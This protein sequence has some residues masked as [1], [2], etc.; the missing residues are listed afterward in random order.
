MPFFGG[1]RMRR[2]TFYS[3][4]FRRHMRRKVGYTSHAV[5]VSRARRSGMVQTLT[6]GIR[7]PLAR[8]AS[9]SS[10]PV[11]QKFDVMYTNPYVT[12]TATGAAGICAGEIVFRLGS[13]YDPYFTGGGGQPEHYLSLSNLYENYLVYWVEIN[14]K[15]YVP[16]ANTLML[17]CC[18]QSANTGYSLVG[19]TCETLVQDRSISSLLMQT[20]AAP[21]GQ[22]E[23]NSGRIYLSSLSGLSKAMYVGGHQTYG[24]AFGANPS[25]TPW[26]RVGLTD[27]QGNAG[28]V[29]TVQVSIR[30]GGRAYG[31]VQPPT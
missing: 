20:A 23:W 25:Q 16:G 14:V 6:S 12:L 9:K 27:A 22:V 15:G 2:R 18:V 17:H 11:A 19:K 10:F 29:A 31:R 3:P 1:Y 8:M 28:N 26:L 7:A 13:I 4:A 30:Y 5:G 21:H 24:A